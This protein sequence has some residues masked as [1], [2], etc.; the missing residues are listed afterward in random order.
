[1][2]LAALRRARGIRGELVAESFG[3]DPDRFTEGL[4]VTLMPSLDFGR[5]RPVELERCWV[6]QGS[7]VLKFAGVDTRTD[8]E[9]LQGWFVCIP[10]EQRPPL[11]E[12]QHYLSDLV[13]CEVVAPD[14][15]R[16][17]VVTGW[18]DIGGPVVLEVGDDLLIPFVP[19]ICVEVDVAGRKIRVELPEGLEEL[20]KK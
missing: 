2:A 16:I 1:M 4:K 3:S 15:R 13:G 7:L 19:Q 18:Q 8:A 20:N 5:G 14:D 17:G 12:G 6:H 11:D 9:A 10:E